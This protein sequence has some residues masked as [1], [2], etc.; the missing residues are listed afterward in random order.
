MF[1]AQHNGFSL[2]LAPPQPLSR[3]ES[4]AREVDGVAE[5]EAW[6]GLR[7]ALVHAD[8]SP[9]DAFALV[10]VPPES[11][12]LRPT[13][14]DGRWLADGDGDAIVVSL[15]L[16]R[17]EPGLRAG[18]KVE[19]EV[20]GV[21]GAWTVAGVM[22]SGPQPIAYVPRAALAARNGG[23]AGTLV[24]RASIAG[25]GAELDL[26]RRMREHLEESGL[27]VAGSQRLAESRRVIEDH[28]A[29]VVQFLGATGWL[30]LAIGGMGLAS[31]LG[32][33][34]LERTRE[35]GVLRAIGARDGQ[36]ARLVA[37][38]GLVVALL[39]WLIAMPLSVPMSILLGEAFG[40]VMFPVPV[41]LWPEP[42]AVLAWLGLALGTAL[43]ASLGPAR[44][45]VRLPVARALAYE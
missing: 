30:M 6:G 21:R 20:A 34:V 26:L 8:G 27:P 40:R 28:L 5:A 11:T 35:L 36:V 12:L 33:A 1:Q 9:G 38:E 14:M 41:R 19:L 45:A 24:V 10:G 43:L 37:G 13:V 32:L 7:A 25:E 42:G 23:L 15:G 17:D 31:S 22:D 18:A 39:A 16:V 29:M 2:R 44:R 3:V 4:V